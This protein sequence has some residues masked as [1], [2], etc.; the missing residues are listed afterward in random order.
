[1]SAIG[2]TTETDLLFRCIT[3]KGVVMC[4][5]HNWTVISYLTDRWRH[6]TGLGKE[7]ENTSQRSCETGEYTSEISHNTW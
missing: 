2:F 3:I 6:K 4:M 7:G 1:M 5:S